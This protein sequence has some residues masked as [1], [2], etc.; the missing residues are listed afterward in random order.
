[1]RHFEEHAANLHT[2]ETA[3]MMGRILTEM[4][5][6]AHAFPGPF[7]AACAAW[8]ADSITLCRLSIFTN[9]PI[10]RHGWKITDD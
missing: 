7:L 1:M 10:M 2:P 6:N 3:L 4:A 5:F 9:T 8:F